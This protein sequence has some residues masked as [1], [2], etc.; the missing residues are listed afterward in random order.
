MIQRSELKTNYSSSVTLHLVVGGR[1]W[2]L[3]SIGPDYVTLRNGGIELDRCQGQIVM[4]IDGEERRWD[5]LLKD[6][7]VPYEPTI[8]INDL[9]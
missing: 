3:A 4:L 7:A 9:N 6:G 1:S 8:R 2:E 5:V